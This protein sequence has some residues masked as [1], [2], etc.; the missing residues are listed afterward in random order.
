M[1]K[2]PTARNSKP[3]MAPERGKPGDEHN[4]IPPIRSTGNLPLHLTDSH[5]GLI[6]GTCPP[7]TVRSGRD[8]LYRDEVGGACNHKRSVALLAVPSPDCGW[9]PRLGRTDTSANVPNGSVESFS[10]REI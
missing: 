6:L 1:V 7:V 10:K 4:P 3:Q 9:S 2:K 8:G 5:S